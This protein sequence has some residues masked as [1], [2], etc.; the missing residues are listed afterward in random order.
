MS[1]G[2]PSASASAAGDGRITDSEARALECNFRRRIGGTVITRPASAFVGLLGR[3]TFGTVKLDLSKPARS[4]RAIRRRQ[5]PYG[6]DDN[7]DGSIAPL[8]QARIKLYRRA[9]L[10]PVSVF[11]RRP[12]I[13]FAAGLS[14]GTTRD[15]YGNVLEPRCRLRIGDHIAIKAFPVPA[16]QY[17]QRIRRSPGDRLAVETRVVVPF[18]SLRPQ[19]A[20]DAPT[21]QAF[22]GIRLRNDVCSGIHLTPRGAEFDERVDVFGSFGSV[23]AAVEVDFPTEFPLKNDRPPVNL[24]INRLSLV[25]PT[26]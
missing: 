5:D 20:G 16:L 13:D 15:G 12:V 26:P 11:N 19:S 18:A 7:D 9:A 22:V 6:Y 25:I 24:R 10:A 3:L 2:D 17:K 21:T 1:G 4:Q 23:R 14:V 8:N